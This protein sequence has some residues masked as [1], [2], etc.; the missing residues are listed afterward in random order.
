MKTVISAR[1]IED[2]L[3]N[4]GD[5]K[6]LDGDAIYTPSAREMLRDLEN[7]RNGEPSSP[8]NNVPSNSAPTSLHSKSPKAELDAAFRSAAWQDIKAQICEVGRR[9]WQ[10]AYVDGNGGNIAVRVGDDIALCTPTLVSKGFMKPDDMCLVDFEGNQ[11]AGPKKRTSEI[12]M[13]LE[14]MKRQKR[15]VATVHCHPPHATAFAVAG[16]EPPTCMIPEIEVF[17]GRVPIAPYRT[18]GTPEMGKLVADLV[19]NHN[20]VLMGNHGAVA[21]SHVN[22]ED[23]YFKMEILEAYCRTVW[24][25]SQLGQP[26]K[27][28]TKE[29]LKDLLRIKQNLGIPDPRIGL[30]EC[31]LCDNDEW[32]PGV[33]CGVPSNGNGGNG[34]STADPEAEALIQA[35]TNQIMDGL[36]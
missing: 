2:L 1:D 32:R 30:K 25:A 33:S 12:L 11:L 16:V 13:H 21:W 15:A 17:I 9:L 29:Q 28:F 20:T 10:R 27:T 23:A 5:P 3:R 14:I 36:R 26:L 22:V 7:R 18:P 8:I 35:I 34:V 24:V 4:G 6:S 19:D 31:E